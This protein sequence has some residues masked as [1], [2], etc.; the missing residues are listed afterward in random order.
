LRALGKIWLH[1]EFGL[2]GSIPNVLY[3]YSYNIDFPSCVVRTLDL[4]QGNAGIGAAQALNEAL[5]G[6][7]EVDDVPNGV[8]VLDCGR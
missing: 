5:L 1:I 6:L 3:G 8:E 7:L 2:R 4:G